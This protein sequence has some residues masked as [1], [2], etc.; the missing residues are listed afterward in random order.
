MSLL[1]TRGQPNATPG[2]QPGT[3]N[4]Y[5]WLLLGGAQPVLTD[6][7][8]VGVMPPSTS[9]N[10][11]SRIQVLEIFFPTQNPSEIWSTTHPN[12]PHTPLYRGCYSRYIRYT[13]NVVKRIVTRGQPIYCLVGG[14]PPSGPPGRRPQRLRA[15]EGTEPFPGHMRANGRPASEAATPGR[16]RHSAS[17]PCGAAKLTPPWVSEV[18]MLVRYAAVATAPRCELASACT[19]RMVPRR[20]HRSVPRARAASF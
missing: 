19:G 3:G 5:P 15:G 9:D 17:R 8:P 11:E 2:I 20:E 1:E 16:L 14:L 13:T 12:P 18:V 10:P 4:R 6:D 7:G